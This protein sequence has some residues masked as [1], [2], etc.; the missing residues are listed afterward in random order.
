MENSLAKRPH[1]LFLFSDTGGGH[2]SAAEAVIEALQIDFDDQVT[3]EMLDF[4]KISPDPFRRMPTLYPYLVRAPH[5]WGLGYRLSNGSKR[6][7]VMVGTVWPL[8]RKAIRDLTAS[9]PCDLIVSVHPLINDPLLRALGKNRPPFITIVTDLATTHAFWYHPQTDL[10]L[11]PTEEAYRRAI[12]W[13]V[14]MERVRVTGLPVSDRFCHPVADRAALRASLGWPKDLPMTVLVGGGEG[15][16]P[17]ATTAEA[18][19]DS[20]ICTGLAIIAGR[21]KELKA[22]LEAKKWP[23]KTFVYGF[24]RNMPD[25]MGAAD[26]LVTKAG[27]GTITEALNAGL[28]MIL[29]SKLPGQEDGNVTFVTQEGAGI[30]APKP[31]LIVASL[32]DWIEH[33]DKRS[34]AAATCQRLARPQASHQIAAILASQVGLVK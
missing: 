1:I 24:V 12:K 7:R 17:L 18:I 3:T 31:N 5:I 21:N 14:P 25:L 30:W 10:C 9:H 20:R 19:A 8:V 22:K 6:T 16:G 26:V 33:P 13:K 2:R 34:R 28:P 4:F 11:V 15:M 32:K 29:Y 23:Y 27:P